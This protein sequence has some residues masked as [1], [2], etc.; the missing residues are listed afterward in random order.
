MTEPADNLNAMCHSLAHIMASAVQHIWPEAKFGVGPV[1]ENGFYY[2]ADLGDTKVSDENFKDI[3]A[4]MRKI[5]KAN[6]P[7]ERFEMDVDE[8][9]EWAKQ[10]GQPYKLE[11][12]NDL[13]RAGTTAAKDI[14]AEELGLVATEASKVEKVSFYRNGDFTDLCRGP[15][16]ESTGKVG[17]FKLMRVSGAYWRGKESNPQV[18]RIYGVAFASEEELKDH[19]QML[20][21]AKQRDHRKLGQE[22]DLFTFSD[23]VGPGLPLWT[24]KGTIVKNELDKFV[25]SMRDD[26][27]FQEVS[28]PHITKK[29]LYEKSGHWAKFADELF[30]ITTREGHEFA[31]KPMNCPHHAQIYAAHP[32][33][34]R[35]LPI[36][37]R[38]TTMCYRDEQSGELN[39][40]SR[41]RAFSQDD[42]HVFCR[43]DQITKE[44]LA[45]WQV[46][47]DFYSAL[48]FPLS[49]RFSTRDLGNMD[50]YAGSTKQWDK[51]EKDLR[52]A[53]QSQ[54]DMKI[55]TEG[56]GEAAFY[57]PKLDFMAEDSMGR[58]WQVATIQLDFA[59]PDGLD[60]TYTDETS[61]ERRPV[62]IHC[63]VMG[64]I[65]RFMSV[66][67][68][69]TA[70]KFP[71]WL[72]PEQVR[73]VTVNQEDKTVKFAD[74]VAEAA[75]ELGVRLNV[76]NSNESVGK[77]IRAAELMKVPYTV[78]IGEKEIESGKLQPRI[79]KDLAVS[80]EDKAYQVEEFL[81]TVANEAKSRVSRTSL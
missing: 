25:Q 72:A 43:E 55:E 24:P 21:E 48:D 36:R 33:S 56:I 13:K 73:L 47:Q 22:L 40:L 70:G 66:Y 34:Y 79:R 7:F 37:Y 28:I 59:Q 35:E 62:M 38:E 61:T 51:A 75:K 4:E 29:E 19:L 11:L 8:A 58:Q 10:N 26:I 3:E 2:D 76:D 20:E 45:L 63:A 68:E 23:L 44:V 1:V 41:V 30:H 81:Q 74:K 57:G 31:M 39:G 9:I 60:L 42:A 78:V 50:D 80:E 69:H 54:K 53:V 14:D 49:L 65:E 27:G 46:V 17:A 71:V 12:L 77:K 52:Q 16:V 64:S 5:I 15:H 18:Q 6:E 32:R 67:I